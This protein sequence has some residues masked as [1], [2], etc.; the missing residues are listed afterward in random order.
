MADYLDVIEPVKRLKRQGR[1]E[2][3]EKLLLSAVDAVE[4]EARERGGGWGVAPWYY[5]QLAIVYRKQ[6]RREDE[7]AILER[8]GH[9]PKAPG[10]KP[11]R[12]ADRL[13]ELRRKS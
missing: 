7:L 4:A 13:K 10:V 5:E 1:L 11:G 8:Y 9:Q 3:A 12:L 2:E 6:G